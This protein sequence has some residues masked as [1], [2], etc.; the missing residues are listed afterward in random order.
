[1]DNAPVSQAI[2]G[3]ALIE[4]TKSVL[5]RLRHTLFTFFSILVF[6]PGSKAQEP[7]QNPKIIIGAVVD[8]MRWDYLYRFQDRFTDG[9]F[10]RLLREGFACE[11]T[12]INYSLTATGPGHTCVYTGSVP[13][14]HGIV[15]NTWYDRS[16]RKEV[17]CVED[18][19]VSSVGTDQASTSRSPHHLL[20]TTIGDELKLSNNFKSKV[21]GISLKDR[22]AILPGGHLSDGSYWYHSG[23]GNFITSTY[24]TSVLPQWL[25][26]FNAQNH[27][28]RY[29]KNN[30]ETLYPIETYVQS[31]EDNKPY[32]RTLI[33]KD[34]PVFPYD[35]SDRLD[36]YGAIRTNPYG[37]S[38]LFD[39]AKAAIDG[40]NLG[41]DEFPDLLAISFSAPDGLGHRVG[42]NAIEIEDMYLRLDQDFAAFFDYLDERFGRDGYLFFITADHGTSQSSG[43]LKENQLPTGVFSFKFLHEINEFVKEKYGVNHVIESAQNA[44]LYLN[45]EEIHAAGS[46]VDEDQLMTDIVRILR[47]QDGIAN[48]WPTRKLG[49]APWAEP[50]KAR[51]INGYNAQRG[52]DVVIVPQPG[53]QASEKGTD[54]G[55]WYP[56]DSHIPLVW[57]GWNVTQGQTHRLIGMTDIAPTLAAL[58]KIQMPSG[59][60]GHPILEITDQ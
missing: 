9:G 52:G 3:I 4:K 2:R 1:M 55:L 28:G 16:I 53:W 47:E 6:L 24:Y 42:T 50:M 41:T 22:G 7:G 20:T 11:N 40:E 13:A 8:Q 5:L 27:A 10:K 59:S 33:G 30:W 57:M 60:V 14:I 32:E 56:F 58:L 31:T 48:A 19:T 51:F 15:G 45:W 49:T 17:N 35:Y 18:S 36:D 37:N 46:N 54:H 38:I 34:E 25:Q 12:Q 23:T 39:L 26:A 43:F 21:I 44:E 29:L